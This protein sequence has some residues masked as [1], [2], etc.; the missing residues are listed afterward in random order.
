MFE[1]CREVIG[2]EGL[3][4]G[5]TVKPKIDTT[6]TH[7]GEKIIAMPAG[8]KG[9]KKVVS[10]GTNDRQKEDWT[11]VQYRGFSRR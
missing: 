3:P 4:Y 1:G 10:K 8:L 6:T 7:T 9:K 5:N 11:K 2:Q